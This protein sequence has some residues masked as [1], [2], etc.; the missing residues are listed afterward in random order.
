LVSLFFF[1]G[2]VL[3]IFALS[4]VGPLAAGR[5]RALVQGFGASLKQFTTMCAYSLAFWAGA[6]FIAEVRPHHSLRVRFFH[7]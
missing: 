3:K 4:L 7:V 6:K 2:S 5:K 1:Q